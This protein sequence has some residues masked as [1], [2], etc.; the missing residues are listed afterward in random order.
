MGFSPPTAASLGGLKPTLP[1][2]GPVSYTHLDVYKRQPQDLP[3]NLS[4]ALGTASLTPMEIAE[5]WAT[6]ANGGYKI[7]PYLIERIEDRNGKLLFRANPARV[8]GS[9]PVEE[10][11]NL[12]VNAT[13]DLPLEEPKV[14]EQ[15]IDERT[16]Y[17]MT[18]MLQ[19]VIKRGT[20]LLYTSRCV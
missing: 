8:P 10:N 18:S 2:A 20:C 12:A 9:E 17:I 14:A 1:T 7:E 16:A 3:R 11:A 19:D 6:F 15:I 13:D 5:G 4:L